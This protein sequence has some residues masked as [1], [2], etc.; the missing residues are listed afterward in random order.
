[1]QK[2]SDCEKQKK[3]IQM[4]EMEKKDRQLTDLEILRKN[5]EFWQK[6]VKKLAK[7]EISESPIEIAENVSK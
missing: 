1:M 7:I 2:A 5:E 6:A 3:E 4:S